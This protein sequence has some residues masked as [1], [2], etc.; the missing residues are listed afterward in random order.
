MGIVYL[1]L[2]IAVFALISML[3]GAATQAVN[4]TIAL[5]GGAIEQSGSDVTDFLTYAFG[6]IDWHG[7]FFATIRQI[8]ET[9]WLTD[10]LKGF[11]DSLSQSTENFGE[12]IA[13]IVATLK[14]AIS[15]AITV[16]VTIALVG[17]AAAN[18]ATRFAVR[19][20][21][22]RRNLKQLIVAYTLVPIFQTVMLVFSLW[23]LTKIKLY[24]LLVFIAL[25][26]LMGVL[27]LCTSYLVYRD[28]KLKLKDILTAKNVFKHFAVLC[29]MA[30]I[31]IVIALLLWQWSALFAILLL[32]PVIIYTANIAD[33]NTDCYVRDLVKSPQPTE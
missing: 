5:V 2:L 1:F 29:I 30:A 9:N 23:L 20:T 4:D 14:G 27:S 25:I 26:L 18:Y 28:G 33:V 16:T 21:V 7:D 13:A 15:D 22:A 32:I 12:D 19:T 31:D 24:S 3:M 8:L 11:F 6:K 17:L 10:T